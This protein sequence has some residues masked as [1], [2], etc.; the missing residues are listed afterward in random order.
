M[1]GG[2]IDFMVSIQD[3]RDDVELKKAAQVYRERARGSFNR[4]VMITAMLDGETACRLW[5][6]VEKGL[7]LAETAA[8]GAISPPAAGR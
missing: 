7:A 1:P 8:K 6:A 5:D 2:G 4:L 3:K